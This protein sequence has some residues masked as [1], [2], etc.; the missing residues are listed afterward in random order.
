MLLLPLPLLL[1]LL[2]VRGENRKA[3]KARI[4]RRN[5]TAIIAKVGLGCL[6][7]DLEGIIVNVITTLLEMRL[8][9]DILYCTVHPTGTSCAATQ[10]NALTLSFLLGNKDTQP[11]EYVLAKEVYV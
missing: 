11:S 4:L 10:T 7:R 2:V 1:L 6:V 5:M 8:C 9:A 3:T